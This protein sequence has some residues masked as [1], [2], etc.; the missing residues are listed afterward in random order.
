VAFTGQNVT[1]VTWLS[2]P[3]RDDVVEYLTTCRDRGKWR[4]DDGGHA[5]TLPV[6]VGTVKPA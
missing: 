2:S 6:Q 3:T 4:H 1:A 5:D